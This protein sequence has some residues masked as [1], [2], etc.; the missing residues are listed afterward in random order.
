MMYFLTCLCL[1]LKQ[2]LGSFRNWLI[3]LFLPVLVLSANKVLPEWN[4]E[5]TVCIGVVLPDS[6]GTQMWQ[7]LE[8]RNDDV[9]SFV[10]T[11]AETLDRNIAAGRWDCGIILA[12][13]FDRKVS[14]L[15]MDRIFTLR[16]GPGSTVYPLVKETISACAAQLVSRDIAQDY[17]FDSG[18]GNHDTLRLKEPDRVLVT[19]TT[20]EKQPL[21]VP[22]LTISGTKDFLRWLI[23]VS[24]LVRMLFGAADLAK[25]SHSSGIK[26]T[27]PLRTPLCSMAARGIADALLLILSASSAM[28]FLGEGFRGCAA[29]LGYVFLW[30]AFSLV[31]AQFPSITTV[32][33]V[34]IPFGVVISFL[35]SSVLLDITLLFP[36]LS[37]VSRWLPVNMFLGACNGKFSNLIHLLIGSGIFLLLA[38]LVSF[39]KSKC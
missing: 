11:D 13:D 2:R 19:M 12:E 18:I 22:E 3:L 23:C 28:V 10:L 14:E 4:G 17:L 7:L 21:Q 27:A 20:L 35:L 31:L 25:W 36:Q 8:N 33:P 32:L 39:R 9:L 29:V 6:G 1:T 38:W 16:I 34:F 37:P 5:A 26:R 24:I 15:D 30:L